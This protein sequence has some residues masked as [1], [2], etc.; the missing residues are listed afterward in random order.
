MS[1]FCGKC[2]APTVDG[3][4]YCTVCG[5]A[6]AD[7]ASTAGLAA[8]ALD[9]PAAAL[10]SVTIGNP[11]MPPGPVSAPKTG[12]PFLKIVLAILAVLVLLGVLTAG[13]CVYF[14]YRAKQRVNQFEKQVRIA[15]PAPPEAVRTPPPPTP[16]PPET[17]TQAIAPLVAAGIPIYP[18]A[19][20]K[21]DGGEVSLG[22]GGVKVQQYTTSDSADK[23]AAFYKDKLGAQALVTQSGTSTLV[24][25]VGTDGVIN[26]TIAADSD[27]GKN[28]FTITSIAR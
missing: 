20:P 18:G 17:P 26:V 8:V 27:P 19:S 21:E 4:K 10:D 3:M 5:S 15:T 9:S 28:L 22:A 24:Q 25:L 6:M 16:A 13:S 12:S 14:L 1:Q 7:S 11:A 2:G 23:I